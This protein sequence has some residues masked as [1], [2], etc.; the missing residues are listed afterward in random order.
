MP[1][2]KKYL[3]T[4]ISAAGGRFLERS[5]VVPTTLI[6]YSAEPPQG[7]DANDL[8]G[9]IKKRREEAESFAG[10]TSS[11]VIPHTWLL[12]AIASCNLPQIV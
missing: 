2:Y 9:V 7:S 11:R 1:N 5:E 12:D 6:V 4:L 8:N 10:N 3:E